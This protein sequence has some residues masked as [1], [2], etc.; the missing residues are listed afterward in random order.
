MRKRILYSL[1]IVLAWLGFVVEGSH[2]LFSDQAALAGNTITTG[3]V[4]LLISNS[5]SSSST[6]YADTR[7]GFAM[8]LVPGGKDE[9]YI[10]LKNA[11]TSDV[12]MDITL[13]AN[14]QTP[15]PDLSAQVI[16]DIL[17]VDGT[18]QPTGQTVTIPLDALQ[19]SQHDLSVSVAKGAT[20][21]LLIRTSLQSLY[22][23]QGQ[24]LA[25]DLTFNGVQ[26]YAP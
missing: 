20:Q 6:T 10:I 18:G 2:A 5:Q 14:L 25:Y 16:L 23:N 24:S 13:A 21:R 15:N 17:P 22:S 12:P 11:S 19:G 8:S 3:S 4:D 1:L 26:H 9:H 7:P